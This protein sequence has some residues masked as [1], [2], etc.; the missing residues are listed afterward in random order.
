MARKTARVVGGNLNG[1]RGLR[2]ESEDGKSIASIAYDGMTGKFEITF[3]YGAMENENMVTVD[4]GFLFGV[5]AIVAE[6]ETAVE[7]RMIQ[8]RRGE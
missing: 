5:A 4:A 6:E 1:F 8:M 3:G 2:V 7:S